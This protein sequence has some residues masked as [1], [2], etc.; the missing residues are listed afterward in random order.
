[1]EVGL[2]L[3]QEPPWAVELGVAVSKISALLPGN[4]HSS[5]PESEVSTVTRN[6]LLKSWPLPCPHSKSPVQAKHVSCTKNLVCLESSRSAGQGVELYE[7]W[8][9]LV[10]CHGL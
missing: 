8:G 3:P 5:A 1:M 10:L 9:T 4:I 2:W 7:M 6:D